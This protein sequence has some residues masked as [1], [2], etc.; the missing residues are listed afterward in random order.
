MI[1]MGASQLWIFYESMVHYSS[2]GY[3]SPQHL[4]YQTLMEGR[5]GEE[6]SLHSI[7]SALIW[8]RGH[9]LPQPSL[10]TGAGQ[11]FL[12]IFVSNMLNARQ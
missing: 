11:L 12:F 8:R 10:Y 6:R 9:P 5:E 1:L 7:Q 3:L 4:T 2:L